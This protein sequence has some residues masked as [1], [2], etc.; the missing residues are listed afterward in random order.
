VNRWTQA[1][2]LFREKRFGESLDAF[3]D[4]LKDDLLQNVSYERNDMSGSF[5]L[6]Q[7]SKIV[8]GRFTQDRLEAEVTLAKMSAASIPVMRRLLE[9]NFNL[10]YSRYAL[11]KDRLCMRF[12]TDLMTANP[13]KLYY[14][15]KELATK[16]DK[17]D[18]LLVHEFGSLE[19]MET[20]HVLQLSENEK[21]VKFDFF[22]KWIKETLD[23]IE[24]LEPEKFSGG[25]A[26]LML[27]L[28]FRI[29]Y[30]IVPEGKLLSDLEKIVDVYYKKGERQTAERNETMIEGFKKLLQKKEEDIFPYLFRS[31][32]TFAIVPPQNQKTITDTISGATQNMY[33][34]RDNKH[35]FI[36]NKVLEYGIS[37]CQ[38]SYSLPKPLSD[39]YRLFMHVNYSDFFQALGFTRQFY[40]E[41]ESSFDRYEI[42]SWIED[43]I[44]LWKSKY[45]R[46]EF[47]TDK[48][49]FQNLVD[50]NHSFTTELA[51]LNL[52]A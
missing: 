16:A 30:L 33:W 9:M 44:I 21:K 31:R 51:A 45:P 37:Y 7:G 40:N 43:T 39:L 14:G 20:D 52:D 48:L 19:S 35:P 27:T 13:N 26:Y 3:F 10:Y 17:Q 28:A 46:L 34:Y 11:H 2:Q 24:P 5:E 6:Y 22:Q 12:D 36:A 8:K 18:D 50:F 15:L 23:Y 47:N 49:N 32:Q 41:K 42:E 38:Y 25:I 29:D 4:Y 1:D